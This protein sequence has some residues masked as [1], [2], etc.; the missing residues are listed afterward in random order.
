MLNRVNGIFS[1]LTGANTNPELQKI[2]QEEA[3]R[4]TAQEDNIYLNAKL[5][6][7]VE[8]IYE[9]RNTLPLDAESKRLVEFLYQKFVM[10]GA[11][12]SEEDKMKLKKLNEEEA[13]LMVRFTNQLLAATKKAALVL[14]NASELA[15]LSQGELDAFAQN[16]AANNLT[17]KWMISLQNTTQQPISQSL[18]DR[19]TRKALFEASWNRAEKGDSNDTRSTIARLAQIRAEKASLLGFPNYASWKLQNQMAK[20]PAA[21]ETFFGKL[22]PSAVIKTKEEAA[23][24][25]AQMNKQNAGLQLEAWD[26]D[27]FAE[28]VRKE[29]YDLD[30]NEVKP[31]LELNRVLENG[32]FYAAESVIWFEF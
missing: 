14:N 1:L 13:S 19:N 18:S 12:L 9:N 15:G 21:V 10:A 32:V 29:K 25:Q 6:V 23:V 2:D 5:F 17:G 3:P 24:L 26:W 16:A 28:Q 22:I 27:Y 8:T 4:L 20:T 31:Y 7:R 30:E 11:R